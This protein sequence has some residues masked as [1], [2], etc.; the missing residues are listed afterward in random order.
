MD[1]DTAAVV[2]NLNPGRT[3]I[4]ERKTS[5]HTLGSY[6]RRESGTLSVSDA[7]APTSICSTRLARDLFGKRGRNLHMHHMRTALHRER[8]EVSVV[9]L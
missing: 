9:Q 7:V 1:D 2:R 3:P 8:T 5:S 6:A 4:G